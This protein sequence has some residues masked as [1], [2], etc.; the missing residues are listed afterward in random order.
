MES[1]TAHA[2]IRFGLGRKGQQALPDNPQSW[3]A[4]QLEGPDPALAVSG[5]TAADGLVA[6]REQR[7]KRQAPDGSTPI[8]TLYRAEQAKYVTN[9]LTTDTPYRE[10]LVTFWAN[11]FTVSLRRGE[12]AAVAHAYIREAIRPHVTGRFSDMLLAVMRHPAMLLYLDNAGSVG[13]DSIVGAR[14]RRGLNENLA[15]ECLELHTVTPAGGYTQEDV[16]SF[17]KVLTGW[18]IE[19]NREPIGFVFRPATH[20]PGD[21]LVMGRTYQAGQEG[22]VAALAWL[23][24]HPATHRNLALKLTRH[25]VADSPPEAVV[26]RVEAVLNRT[27]GDLKQAALELLRLPE[28]WQSLTKLRSP[29][30]YIVAVLRAVDLPED[31]RPPDVPGL[32]AG[33]GQ[34]LLNAPLPNGWPDTATD[35]AGSEAMLRRIDWAYG[36]TGRVAAMDPEQVGQSALGPLLTEATLTQMRRAGSRRDAMTLLLASPEF[37]RR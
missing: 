24:L 32:M 36:F 4:A 31:K 17:A 37:Q 6:I 16:T 26:R 25:F 13:P 35:W 20:Q 7:A 18:S 23:A 27:G 21:K 34:P 3:L 30:D 19:I 15:R 8:R 22:G 14:Q 5:A 12:C 2:L 28:A 33:L 9:L 10:R 11:H 29:S 1:Q